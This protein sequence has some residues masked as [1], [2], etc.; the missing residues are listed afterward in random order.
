[1]N[2]QSKEPNPREMAYPMTSESAKHANSPAAT[3]GDPQAQADQQ[4]GGGGAPGTGEQP[5]V[6]SEDAKP[7]WSGA[8]GPAQ[9][10][11]P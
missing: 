5:V 8:K 6:P 2:E 11:K 3:G 7:Q 1:M 4:A 10:G 9:A